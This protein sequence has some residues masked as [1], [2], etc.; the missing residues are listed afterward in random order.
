[1]SPN[2]MTMIV[3]NEAVNDVINKFDKL[4][5]ELILFEDSM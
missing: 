3:D 5:D 1:M 2:I 4:V